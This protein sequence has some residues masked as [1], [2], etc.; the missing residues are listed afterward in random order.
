MRTR[1]ISPVR[2]FALIHITVPLARLAL[3]LVRALAPAYPD[4]IAAAAAQPTSLRDAK[5][6]VRQW[7][8]EAAELGK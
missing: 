4:L 1:R 7:L 2:A 3:R 5:A 6:A 8:Y